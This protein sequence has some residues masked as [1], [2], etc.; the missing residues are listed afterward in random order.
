VGAGVDGFELLDAGLGVS[1][2][3]FQLLISAFPAARSL[4]DLRSLGGVG[5]VGGSAFKIFAFTPLLLSSSSFRR[6]SVSAFQ[7]FRISA[8]Q[9]FSFYPMLRITHNFDP[10]AP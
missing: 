4:P 10:A 2:C 9:L 1:A 5:G 8:F 7:R 3:G 6:F